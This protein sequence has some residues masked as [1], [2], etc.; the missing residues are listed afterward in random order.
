MDHPL[1]RVVDRLDPD[2]L[3]RIPDLAGLLGLA[4]SSTHTLASSGWL[5]GSDWERVPG[6][7]GRRLVWTGAALVAAADTEPLAL[8]H[9]RYPPSTLWRLGCGCE[10]CLAWHNDDS[11]A[12]RRTVADAQ[13][14]E[15]RRR[16]V[17]DLVAA[18]DVSSVGEAAERAG[19]TLGQVYG[20]ARRD[21]DFRASLDEA[22]EA[23]CV[24][25]DRCGRPGGYRA[26]CRGTACRRAHRPLPTP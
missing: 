18:G 1:A 19:V 25:G 7:D 20:L 15:Q 14:P 8:D 4:I 5:P 21:D 6:A 22:A 17:L 23:L 13:F 26:G 16:Q 3:Y 11:R 24:G 10:D 2:A 9:D 12:R